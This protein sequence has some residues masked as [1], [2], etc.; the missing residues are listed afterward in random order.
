MK[1]Q[2]KG[3]RED[4][5]LVTGR[6]RFASDWTFP[7]QTYACFLRADRAHAEIRSVDVED[8]RRS[9][10]VLAV[11]TGKD[12]KAAGFGAVPQL[13]RFPGKGG[14]LIKVPHRE[15]LAETRVRFVGQEVAL[16]VATSEREAQD[17][18]EKIVVDYR[19]LPVVIDAEAA[20]RPGA[21]ELYPGEIPQNLSFEYEYGDAAKTEEAFARAAHVTLLRVNAQ[22]IVGTPMEPKAATAR[23]DAQTGVYDLHAP[24]QGMTLMSGSLSGGTGIPASKIRVHAHDV[25][26]GFGVRTEGYSEYCALMLAAKTVGRPVKWTGSRSETI[27][28]DHHG[29]DARM[30]GELALDSEGNFLAIRVNWIVNCGGYLSGAGPFINTLPAAGHSVNLYKI[31]VVYGLHRL[32]LTNTTP[33]T[34][35]RGAGRPN[36]SYLVERLVDEAARETGVDRVELRRR[37][38]IRKE[39]FPYKAPPLGFEYDSGD[40]I[41]LLDVALERSD[42]KNYAG[43]AAQSASQGKLRGIG[44]AAFIEPAGGGGSPQEEVAIKFGESGNPILYSVSGPSG[45]GHE[46]AYPEIVAKVFG[47]P[48][49]TITHRAS[50]PDG[51]KLMGDGTIGSRSTMSQGVGLHLAATEVVRKAKELAAEHLEA[52]VADLEFAGGRYSVRGTDVSVSLIELVRKHA[53]SEG[54]ALD[55]QHGAPQGRAFPTGV[56]VAEVEIDPQTGAIEIASYVA[57]DD[58]GNIINHT[59]VDGQLHGGIVQG[60]GQAIAEQCVYD[61]TS[62]Q[63]ITGSFMDYE[64]PRAD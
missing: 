46:T 57:V 15:V 10:G 39:D 41:G 40:P 55:T 25:G 1:N 28:S 21:P 9:P 44:I 16:V 43:R 24:T 33:T 58:C 53:G 32:A 54:N 50:D 62:G 13:V 48:A 31:P 8:A 29:R 49:E 34:A 5:R 23:Y 18:I 27:V 2:F 36:V 14:A 60:L 4:L 52:A 51:P 12:T 37:N 3:R 45:Q 38:L 59:L 56:H 63:L 61:P 64:M 7:D 26:G 20:L 11:L 22:R 17:A 19:D 35:Y 6:G 47:V 42:W 30:I